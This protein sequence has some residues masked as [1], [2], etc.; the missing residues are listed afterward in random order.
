MPDYK[1][2]SAQNLPH[3]GLDPKDD[4]RHRAEAGQRMRDSLFWEMIMPDEQIGFQAYLYL[5]GAGKAGFNVCVWGAEEKPLVLDLVQGAVADDADLGNFSFEGLRLTQPDPHHSA[6]LRYESKKVKLELSYTALHDPFSYRQNPDGIPPWFAINRIE[7]TGWI[8]GFLEFGGRR[9]EWDRIGHRDH[10]WGVRN[11]GAPQHWK[12]FVAY[13]RDGRR[14][15]NG[16]IWIARGEWGFG[17]YVVCD[18][19]LL[20]ISHIKHHAEYD[21]DMSQRRL[22]AEIFDVRGGSFNLTLERFGL[23]KLPTNDKLGTIIM[24]AACTATIDGFDGA[25]QFE[26][27]WSTS[28]LD[29]LIESEKDASKS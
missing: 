7:Q 26:T 9:I 10:S 17:G 11:W 15:V 28:Y 18:G 4:L 1:I 2:K 16:W 23:V 25:G 6:L 21:A 5:T 8:K 22:N 14:I 19:E 24:E 29:H 3:A 20:A 27:H 12:W 13:T